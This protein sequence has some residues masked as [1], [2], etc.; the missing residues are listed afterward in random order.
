MKRI[1]NIGEILFWSYW[2]YTLAKHLNFMKLYLLTFFLLLS[3]C[4]IAQNKYTISGYIKDANSKEDLNGANFFIP[5]IGNGTVS[6]TYGLYSITLEEGVYQAVISYLGYEEQFKEITLDK[7]VQLNITLKPVQNV[8]G[9]VVISDTKAKARENVERPQMGIAEITAKDIKEIPVIAGEKDLLKAL[10]LLPGVQS[11]SEGTAGFYVRGGGPDQ[12]LILLDEALVYNPYHLFGFFSVFNVDAIKNVELIKGGFPAKYGGR[13]SSILDISLK[14]GNKT[15]FHGEGGIGNISSRLTLEGPLIKDKA[16][17][18][19]S[20]RRTYLD[21]LILLATPKEAKDQIPQ[22]FFYDLNAKLNFQL[23]DKDR[24]YLSGYF[25]KDKFK[26]QADEN[27]SFSV[28]WGNTTGTA[29]WNHVF[30]KKLFLN[31]SAIY[32]NY[33]FSFNTTVENEDSLQNVSFDI[34]TGIEDW[35]GKLDFDYY[36]SVL[37]KVKFGLN[38]TN[39]TFSPTTA[40]QFIAF[41][42]STITSPNMQREV[43][44]MAAY[45]S[46]EWTITNNFSTYIGLRVPAF[47]YKDTRYIGVEPRFIANYQINKNQSIKASYT[48]MNQYS[49]LLTNSSLSFPWDIWVPSSDIIKPKTSQQVAAGYYANFKDDEYEVSVEGYYKDMNNMIEYKE[50]A[51]IFSQDTLENQLTFGKG[52]SYGAELYIKRR[53]GRLHGWLGYTL[54]WSNRQFDEL[55]NRKK[56]AAKYDRRHDLSLVAIYDFNS[57]WSFS[58]AFVY[59][60]GH[61]LTL[62]VGR[63]WIPNNELGGS[64][65]YYSDFTERNGFKLNAYNRLD[66]G[67]KRTKKYK[68]FES[69]M[70]FDIYNLYSRRNPYFVYLDQERDQ[71]SN[72]NKFVAKQVSLLPMVPSASWNFKF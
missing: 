28:P 18:I 7:D 59:G 67:I 2:R 57:K 11:G 49:H 24:L 48:I 29:R 25:G 31:A 33:D 71:L 16:S 3:Q 62:P 1:F 41:L 54:S 58:A 9:E 52:T 5:S 12:N 20:G 35:T 44:E 56:F 21:Q 45:I 53:T 68:R 15:S 70:R 36:P 47:V 8:I 4:L 65:S 64:G 63:I 38:Y 55:N 13:L 19:V 26:V 50:G 17:F 60:S 6:N 43:H 72:E 42:D 32:T 34:S 30:G 22:V 51:D 61:S 46:D 23:T 40:K 37:H 39:H 66:L 27:L 10:Q 69:I 14:D